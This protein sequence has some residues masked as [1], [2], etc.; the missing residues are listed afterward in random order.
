MSYVPIEDLMDHVDSKYRLVIVAAKRAKQLMRGAASLVAPR[1]FK[2]TYIAMEEIASGKLGFETEA[3]GGELTRELAAGEAKA[4]WFRNLAAEEVAAEEVAGE[5][6]GAY[7]EGA[8]AEEAAAEGA[9]AEEAEPEGAEAEE[10]EVG[11][12]EEEGLEDL[13]GIE[14]I[15]R[16]QTADE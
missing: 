16:E 9:E 8:E 1:A 13:E 4:T 15:D 6:E 2:P 7:A 3:L 11:Q 5:E 12:F 14:A 10:A